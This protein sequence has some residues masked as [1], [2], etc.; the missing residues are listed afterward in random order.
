VRGLN[1]PPRS[2]VAPASATASAVFINCCSLSTEHGPAITTS[3]F[4]P[5]T[6]PFGSLMVEFA[7]CDSRLTS[8]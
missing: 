4:P 1:A 5:I 3:F 7:L 6:V 8:L 2:T